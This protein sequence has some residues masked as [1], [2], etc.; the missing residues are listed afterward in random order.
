[1]D[2]SEQLQ[3]VIHNR[4]RRRPPQRIGGAV[5]K[6][7]DSLHES[8]EQRSKLADTISVLVDDDFRAHCRVAE[9]L[10]GEL[11][12]HVDRATLVSVMVRRWAS[13]LTRALA[14]RSDPPRIRA[15]RFAFGEAGV[16]IRVNVRSDRVSG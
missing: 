3:W 4:K 14:A 10:S 13:E 7:V 8:D 9:V 6:L 16:A 12:L 1:M 2:A 5:A 15:V 11:L